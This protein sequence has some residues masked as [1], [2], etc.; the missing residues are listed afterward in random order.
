MS[1]RGLPGAVGKSVA[2][3]GAGFVLAGILL[4]VTNV[5]T[6]SVEDGVIGAALIT[7]GITW[8]LCREDDSL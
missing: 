1:R 7:L 4:G 2:I 3:V 6:T 5:H 8:W